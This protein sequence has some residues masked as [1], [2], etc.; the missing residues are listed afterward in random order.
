MTSRC[1]PQRPARVERVR[2]RRPSARRPTS[3]P[4]RPPLPC[5]PAAPSGCYQAFLNRDGYGPKRTVIDVAPGRPVQ[6]RLL[7]D[8][9]YGYAWPKWS[10][11]GSSA[12]LRVSSRASY[13]IEL[14]RR[15]CA[16]AAQARR[17]A[18]QHVTGAP[19]CRAWRYTLRHHTRRRAARRDGYAPAR[20]QS[21]SR[22]AARHLGGDLR[23]PGGAWPGW[24]DP[25]HGRKRHLQMDL[26][27]PRQRVPPHWHGGLRRTTKSLVLPAQVYSA[28]TSVS[29]R[30]RPGGRP[31]S[32]RTPDPNWHAMV[33]R[34]GCCCTLLLYQAL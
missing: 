34:C 33:F 6:L 3:V 2:P 1:L 22:A 21:V 8:Q 5:R 25:L 17:R 28:I 24:P 14:C 23:R 27:E 16:R 26:A 20:R 9:I 18:R 32:A 4:P 15:S 7:G 11:A 12:Q 29:S 31:A 13:R 19:R 30:S 10:A